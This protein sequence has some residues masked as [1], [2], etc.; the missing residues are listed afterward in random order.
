MA[1]DASDLSVFPD[2]WPVVTVGDVA[3]VK[4]GKRMPKGTK[5]VESPTSH[6][7]LRIV[8]FKNGGIEKS[9][10]L[11]VPDDVFPRIAKYTISPRDVY[12][13]IVGTIGIVGTIDAGLDGANLTEN[14]A[15]ICNLSNRLDRDFLRYY[16]TSPWGRF[17]IKSRTVGSTQPKLA[18][19]RIGQIELPLPPLSEQKAIAEILGG[20]DAKIELNR[21]MNET[22]ESLA[23]ALFKSWF[24]DFDPVR[25]NCER[26]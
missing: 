11:Y 9:Q 2:S 8:D 6:P 26:G 18:L 14:A 17:Q 1:G 22:L 19:F 24:V 25:R 23:R 5:L 13:S 3:E 16:L 10:L 21:R 15:K 20:L 7:Y 12:I 4:S